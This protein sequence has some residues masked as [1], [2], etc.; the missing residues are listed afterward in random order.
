[1]SVDTF[2]YVIVDLYTGKEK[3]VERGAAE[4]RSGV[5]FYEYAVVSLPQTEQSE[6]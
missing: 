1:M 4:F 3:A 2:E 5:S 6:D